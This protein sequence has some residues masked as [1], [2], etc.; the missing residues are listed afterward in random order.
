MEVQR[1]SRLEP[2]L[3][4]LELEVMLTIA[5]ASS[6]DSGFVAWDKDIR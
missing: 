2:E 4:K 1:R 3:E 6:P 5:M